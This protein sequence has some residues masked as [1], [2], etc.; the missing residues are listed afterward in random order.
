MPCY[1][2]KVIG[3]VFPE[4]N[5]AFSMLSSKSSNAIIA[6]A[7]CKY[8][9]SLSI[10]DYTEL[11]ACH[12]VS[13]V[14]SYLKTHT[15]YSSTLAGMNE[16]DVHRG[17][18]EVILKQH[19]YTDM[20]S[21]SKYETSKSFMA[22]SY[23]LGRLEIEQIIK[24]LTMLNSGNPEDYL[25]SAPF[26]FESFF[27]INIQALAK[28]GSFDEVIEA[29]KGTRYYQP[30]KKCRPAN[31]NQK[32]SLSAAE[33]EMMKALFKNVFDGIAQI[34]NKKEREDLNNLFSA[35]VDFKNIS[36]IIR[37]KKYYNFS[38]DKIKELLFPYGKLS[39]KKL[40]NLCET[41]NP[42]DVL[43]IAGGTYLGGT[44]RKLSYNNQ[45][46]IFYALMTTY[47]KHLLRFSLSPEV[48]MTAYM[49]LIDTELVNIVNII[50]A[51]RYTISSDEK[52]KLLVL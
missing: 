51:T 10:K 46:Q 49:F 39:Q 1:R 22:S 25:Y 41:D 4:R 27:K 36:I 44:V 33:T 29:L 21:L 16:N 14:A 17:Q 31:E 32:I 8:G 52:L 18:L 47:C 42:K 35:Y 50:E 24:C 37:L 26:S 5:G 9:K 45:I 48:V 23:L 15:V 30:L 13:E 34:K 6:K 20:I 19:L 38:P 7:R 2:S 43:Q 40:D 12:T 28:A 3:N 11:T